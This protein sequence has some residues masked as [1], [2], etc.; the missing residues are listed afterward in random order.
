MEGTAAL[1]KLEFE[2]VK[3]RVLHYAE[4]EPGRRLL[5]DLLPSTSLSTV[6]EQ[7]ARVTEMKRLLVEEDAVPLEGIHA[8]RPALQKSGVEGATLQPR[9]LLQIAALLRVSRALR[10]FAAKRQTDCPML[11]ELAEPLHADKVVEFNIEQAIDESEAVK[12]GASREL[13]AIRR[14]IAEKYESLKKRLQGILKNVSTQGFSQ[15]EIITTREGRMVIPVKAEFKGHVPG[16]IH[17]ASSSGATVFIEPADTLDLNNEIRSLQFQEQREVERILR[18]LTGQVAAIRDPLLLSLEMLARIDSVHARA[19]YSIEVL[20]SEPVIATD[21]PLRLVSARHP[22]LVQK[23]GYRS[24]V[25]LD[26]EL[27]AGYRTLVISGPNA[28]GKSVAMKTVGLLVLMAQ[29]GLHIPAGDGTRLPMFDAILVDIGDDQS[30]ENDLSTFSSHLR[31]LRGIADAAGERTLVLI[32]E[33]GAGTDPA[34]GGAL[35]AAMLEHLTQKHAWTIAT[36]HH[37]TLKAFAYEAEGVENGA[38]EFDR[39]T[40]TPTYR[41]RSGIPGS[42][43]AIEMASRLGFSRGLLGRT[44]E[45]LGVQQSRL[46]GLIGELEASAQQSRKEMEELRTE[47]ARVDRLI[48]EYETKIRSQAAELRETKRRALEEARDIVAG[49]NAMIERSVREIRETSAQK[50]TVKHLRDDVD[51]LRQE[52]R[53]QEETVVPEPAVASEPEAVAG[54]STVRLKAGTDT[55]EVLSISADGK[56]AV[57]VFGA[58][59]MKVPVKDLVVA[60]R[61]HHAAPR[62]QEP[63]VD[64]QKPVA[65]ELDVRGLSG[66]EA[67]PLVDKFIDDAVLAGLHRVD[68]IHGKGTGVLRKKVGE[69]LTSHP[70]VKGFHIA[71]WNEGGTGATVVELGDA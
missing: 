40:L 48:G 70:R 69:F 14:S 16:F 50:E 55:G 36:T 45:L 34:E 57:V 21:G 71:E 54:G 22:L 44:R 65:R 23:H 32:D 24:T 61:G 43:Y 9:E 67:L 47:K 51:R 7:L 68:I 18:V 66:E 37:G 42:S 59:K 2:A 64:L 30:I 56:Q 25:P 17:S 3:A 5:A 38:M 4:S 49:A 20:G 46:D 15:D 33:I 39:A 52:I 58:V 35:A 1:E 10:A 13:Q 41:F 6:R 60:P 31:N 19:K 26:L 8:V 27:G 53:R 11:W 28:G 29:A 12:A 63:V 62:R